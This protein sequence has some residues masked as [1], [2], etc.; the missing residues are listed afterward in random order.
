[1]NTNCFHC[2]AFKKYNKLYI[3]YWLDSTALHLLKLVLLNI[4]VQSYI[5]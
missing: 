1:M 3:G 2:Y 4:Y 5:Y